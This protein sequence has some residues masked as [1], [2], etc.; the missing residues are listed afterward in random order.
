SLAAFTVATVIES[1]SLTARFALFN[2][3]A[4][5]RI[6]ARLYVLILT[7]GLCGGAVGGPLIPWIK[8]ELLPLTRGSLGAGLSL[9]IALFSLASAA[10]FVLG[11]RKVEVAAALCR[12]SDEPTS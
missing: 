7:I 10:L 6:R 12:Q 3:M 9:T 8:D 5:N 11:A 4:P 2:D 1:M